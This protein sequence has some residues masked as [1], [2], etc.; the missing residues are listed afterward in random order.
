[1]Q[2]ANTPTINADL[3]FGSS[4]LGDGEALI[5]A[6]NNTLQ[7]NGKIFASEVV[8]SGTAFLNV[9][10]DQTQFTGNWVIN[11]GGIQ[12]LTPEAASTGEVILNGSR[13]NDRDS[14]YSIT[15]VRYN[16]N[17]GTPDLFTWNSGKIVAYDINRIYLPTASDRLQQ[18]PDIDLRTT[19]AVAGSGQEGTLFFQVDSFRSTVR[20][21][22]VTLHDHYL[23]HVESGS[24]GTGSTVGVQ[25][26]ALDGTGGLNNQ[27]L[28]DLRKVGDGVLTL[29]DNTAS[30]TG[31]RTI[32]VGEG[33]LRVLHNGAAGAAGNTLK[34][35]STGDPC[36]RRLIGDRA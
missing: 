14:T 15:E 10:S 26:G 23:L 1:M 8:K 25:F 36:C 32:T 3:Y 35:N 20:T 7:I 33:S 18:I 11:G 29:G 16:F 22:T 6:S 34:V 13:M 19:N 12:F 5:W 2:A 17:S 24:F 9:R 21:G 30:F 28:F 27:G 31:N 4:G